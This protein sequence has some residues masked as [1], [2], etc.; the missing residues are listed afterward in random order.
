MRLKIDKGRVPYQSRSLV[1]ELPL[2][3]TKNFTSTINREVQHSGEIKISDNTATASIGTGQK[4]NFSTTEISEVT[5]CQVSTKGSETKPVWAFYLKALDEDVL[6]GLVDKPLCKVHVDEFPCE[7]IAEF[8]VSKQDVWFLDAEGIWPPGISKNK[9][10]IIERE[11]VFHL[12]N[13]ILQP[14]LSRIVLTVGRSQQ[15]IPNHDG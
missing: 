12:L 14:Y 10:A 15:E 6:L 4:Q 5:S 13:S 1:Q 8:R 3:I 11:I 2:S 7:V 9:R